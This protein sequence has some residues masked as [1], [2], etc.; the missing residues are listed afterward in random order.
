MEMSLEMV[1]NL[2]SKA[3]EQASSE[4]KRPI[5][6][7]VC[8]RYGF[9]LSFTRM[10]GATIRSIPISQGKA[11]TA[12]FMG[13]DTDAFSERLY[14]ENVPASFFCDDH[15]TGLPGGV[16]LKDSVGVIIGAAGVSGLTPQEDQSIANMMAAICQEA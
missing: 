10:P 11:Y 4:F 14:R 9:L 13:M 2:I 15:L 6:V 3:I 12:A 1:Q 7:A 16:V 5:C 8:D